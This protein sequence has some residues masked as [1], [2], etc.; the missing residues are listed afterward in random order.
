MDKW[1]LNLHIMEDR[2]AQKYWKADLYPT[3][4]GEQDHWEN[5]FT[6]HSSYRSQT[7]NQLDT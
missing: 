5:I 3:T 2:N 1:D 6:C 7:L 4:F